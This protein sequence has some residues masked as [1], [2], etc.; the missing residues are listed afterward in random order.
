[1][2]IGTPHRFESQDDAEDQILKLVLLS[3]SDIRRGDVMRAK[4]LAEQID[5]INKRF[6]GTKLLDR[7]C[8]FNIMSQSL[9]DSLS[10][11]AADDESEAADGYSYDITDLNTA[12]TP[13]RRDTHFIGHAF[14]A[15]GRA[16]SDAIN[17]LDLIRDEG[18]T[19]LESA[20]E[21]FNKNGICKPSPC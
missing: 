17:H 12:V 6:L 18:M 14:E 1:M 16:R 20:N 11:K 15:S 19:M 13:F 2:F 4:Y 10:Y 9:T 7:A 5:Q 3:G 8:I 21:A